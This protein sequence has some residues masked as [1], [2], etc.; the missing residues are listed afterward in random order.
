MAAVL[1]YGRI[2]GI[3]SFR[4][5]RWF[6]FWTDPDTSYTLIAA[7]HDAE[8]PVDRSGVHIGGHKRNAF[9]GCLAGGCHCRFVV[10]LSEGVTEGG[11]QLALRAL[12]RGGGGLVA[13]QLLRG[14]NAAARL[15]LSRAV[16]LH[17]A[18]GPRRCTQHVK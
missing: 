1:G 16:I 13:F 15:K 10:Q 5:P 3:C 4:Y 12:G 17:V 7:A 2:T 14:Q 8:C 18:Q 9:R 11:N 6:C